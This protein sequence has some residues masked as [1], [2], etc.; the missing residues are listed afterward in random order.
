MKKL[1][2]LIL[3]IIVLA[4]IAVAHNTVDGNP[5]GQVGDY[6]VEL[7]TIPDTPTQDDP[8]AVIIEVED[9][10]GN[11][12]AGLSPRGEIFR[13]FFDF[14]ES[15]EPGRYQLSYTFT[16]FGAEEFT[17][18]IGEELE[19]WAIPVEPSAGSSSSDIIF[20]A[21]L[22]LGLGA[23][24]Y[25][26][27]VKKSMKILN[28]AIYAVV[29]LVA[30]GLGYSLIAYYQ[31]PAVDGCTIQVGDVYVYHCHQSV[32]VELCGESRGFDWE[33][34]DLNEGHTHKGDHRIHWH[35]DAPSPDPFAEMTLGH[36][37]EDFQ[38]ELTETSVA[39]PEN[40]QDV[41]TIEDNRCSNPDGA[42]LKVYEILEHQTQETEITDFLNHHMQ[43]EATYRIV[44]S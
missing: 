13:E 24:G 32:Q 29:L 9:A 42:A 39:D 35:P 28:G 14:T 21:V 22:V 15:D 40:L 44:Y 20:L 4:N 3:A 33:G 34:G 31:S 36:L 8:A 26:T 2:P 17:V 37:F 41:Y 6:T 10:S 25:F 23:I 5:T 1:L 16:K 43:D 11:P 19:T 27:F 12:V 30:I 7:L 38:I 18:H